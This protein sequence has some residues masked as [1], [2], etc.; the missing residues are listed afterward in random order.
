MLHAMSGLTDGH[1]MQMH[2]TSFL[3]VYEA[4]ETSE[5]CFLF[6]GAGL[7]LQSC[8]GLDGACINSLTVEGLRVS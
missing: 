7:I 1:L 8:K 3:Q 6:V 2:S 4:S 5:S